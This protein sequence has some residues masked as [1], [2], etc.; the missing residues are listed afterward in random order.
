MPP[1]PKFTREEITAA[2]LRVISR[3]GITALTAQT[4]GQDF[5]AMLARVKSGGLNQ[6]TPRPMPKF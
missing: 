1:K 5:M 6:Q 3:S 4:L 2:A